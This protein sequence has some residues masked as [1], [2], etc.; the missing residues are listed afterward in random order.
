MIAEFQP[1]PVKPTISVGELDRIDVRV[2]EIVQVEDIEGSKQLLKLT[3][4]FGD[5]RR[6]VLAG[7]KQE[8]N[9][10]REIEGRQALFVVNLEPRKIMGQLSEA[11]LFD[12]GYADGIRPAL[13]IPET[14][15]PNGTRA[16]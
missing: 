11:M 3:V 8:R 4:D 6:S 7:M 2:G 10:P 1:A 5:H 12:L 15:V 16:G 9:D 13:A 14:R